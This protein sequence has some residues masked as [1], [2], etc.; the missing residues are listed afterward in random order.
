MWD[1]PTIHRLAAQYPVIWQN[2]FEML[3]LGVGPFIEFYGSQLYDSAPQRL[4]RVLL[5][6]A[7]ALG[8]RNANGIE[9][10][11]RNEDL[12]HAAN[13]T[14]FTASR[15]LN[16]WQRKKLIVKTRRKIVLRCPEC[17]LLHEF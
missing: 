15:L 2:A 14:L 6:V 4:A 8:R 5:H 12:A 17:L 11:I 10:S 16:Q 1:R 7:E 3:I 9:V 13:V